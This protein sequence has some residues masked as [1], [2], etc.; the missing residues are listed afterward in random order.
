MTTT[1][2]KAASEAQIRALIDDR[3]KAIR[4]KDVDA[5]MS[6]VAPHVLTFDVVN[7]L[8]Y[9]GSGG[10]RKRAEEWFST[11]R[12]PLEY[13]LRDLHVAVGDDVAFSH[14][15][16]RVSATTTDGRKLDMW[17]RATVCYRK[18]DGKWMITHEHSSVP[19]DVESGEASLGLKP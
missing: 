19:F 6:S 1:D 16:N 10:M 18:I 2:S 3:V 8:Q 15:L 12:G 13:E 5:A 11:F 4:A 14:S 17:W 9:V 7:P